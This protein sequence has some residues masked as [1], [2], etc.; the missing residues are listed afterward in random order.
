MN[1]QNPEDSPAARDVDDVGGRGKLFGIFR[2]PGG[3]RATDH[4]RDVRYSGAVDKAV[5]VMAGMRT[6]V[7]VVNIS[8]RGVRIKTS[9]DPEV[10]E[11]V[12]VEFDGFVPL[13]GIVRWVNEGH[14]G[15]ELA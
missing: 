5:V 1:A 4:R 15:I 8:E 2:L 7:R 12:S 3:R 9:L 13:R 6:S 14:V 10:G 11:S